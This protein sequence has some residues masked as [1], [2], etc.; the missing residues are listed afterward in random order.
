MH[1]KFKVHNNFL[2]AVN[3]LPI[4]LNPNTNKVLRENFFSLGV[5]VQPVINPQLQA[6]HKLEQSPS[7]ESFASFNPVAKHSGQH[8]IEIIPIKAW[9]L[10]IL[11][12]VEP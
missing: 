7:L 10:I 12:P 6:T 5:E 4:N 2:P 3:P 11:L 1:G 9:K 8:K